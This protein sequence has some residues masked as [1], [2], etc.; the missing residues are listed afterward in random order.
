[1]F[2]ILK[3]LTQA[4][5]NIYKRY[6]FA[7]WR[8]CSL[9]L[10]FAFFLSACQ[11]PQATDM[12]SLAPAETLVYLESKDLGDMLQSLTQSEAYKQL[13][14]KEKDFSLL[15]NM[16]IAVVVTGFETSEKQVTDESSILN[17]KPRFVM[18]ANTHGWES[19]AVS[20]VENQLG[21]FV[22]EN[23]GDDVTLEKSAKGEAKFF[24]WTAKDGRKLF[25]AVAG[26]VIYVGNDQTI[27]DKCLAVKKG[28]AE[29][30]LKNESLARARMRVGA[31]ALAFGYVSADG[32]SQIANLVGVSVAMNA[33]EDDLVR[34]FI[35]KILPT[36]L[37]KS[38][39]EVIWTARKT[40][41]GIEDKV[42]FKTD[43]EVSTVLKETLNPNSNAQ[44]QTAQFLPNEFNSL[45]RYNLQNPNV[46][47]KSVLLTAS[48]QT[49]AVS[50]KILTAV[51]GQ[52]FEPY[53][54]TDAETFLNSVGSEII[55]AQIDEDGDKTIVIVDVKDEAGIKKSISNEINFKSQ[56]EKL[57][58]A[59]IW[60]SKDGE[61]TAAVIEG[62]LI[63]GESESVLICLKAKESGQNFTKN[64]HFQQITQ[65]S[66]VT[67]TVSKDTE[68]A[69]KIVNILGNAKDKSKKSPSFY[70]IETSFEASGIE[71]KTVSDF[72]LIGTIIEQF[73]EN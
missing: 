11:K 29:N 53:G 30:L 67:I 17:F 49:D 8:L 2:K 44:F 57:G 14:V 13:A 73:D 38:V 16:Q 47:W 37:Q 50:G 55:T 60:K 41:Q 46:A 58:N 7:S 22:K 25:G 15:K 42:L 71:R 39:T 9:A 27:L 61:L 54:I 4:F 28:E 21:K 26:S 56:P 33:S 36:I 18:M 45:T 64:E 20:I 52:F 68:S 10:I 69:L 3:N 70:T 12:R 59:N 35:A 34:S 24:I 62:K 40:E 72:G 31:D 6:N 23:Y 1:M 19:T 32:A 66:A 48:K 5:L 65:T 63:L 43:A 51:S